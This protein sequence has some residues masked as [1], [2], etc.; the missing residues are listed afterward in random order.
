MGE[1]FYRK[2]DE[3]KAKYATREAQEAVLRTMGAEEIRQLAR[4][5]GSIQEACWFARFAQEAA[6]RAA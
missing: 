5:C 6:D 3:F 1:Y 2:I 4:A